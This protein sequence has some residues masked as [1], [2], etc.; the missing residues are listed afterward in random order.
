M[1]H[2]VSTNGHY[3]TREQSDRLCYFDID[4]TD[5]GKFKFRKLGRPEWEAFW[6]LLPPAADDWPTITPITGEAGSAGR[7][8][9]VEANRASAQARRQ[10]EFEWLRQQPDDEQVRY[11]ARRNDIAFRTIAACLLLPTYTVA[12]ARALG[13]VADVLYLAIMT[14]SGLYKEPTTEST[15]PP[16]GDEQQPVAVE[17]TADAG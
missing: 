14:K 3:L 4:I 13:D 6:P 9:S 17:A 7:T 8:A 5:V 10:A 2:I 16:P 15:A 11:Q 12:Q 1:D